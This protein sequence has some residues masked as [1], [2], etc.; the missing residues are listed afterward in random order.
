MAG[1]EVSDAVTGSTVSLMDSKGKTSW[2]PKALEITALLEDGSGYKLILHDV[3]KDSYSSLSVTSSG[4]TGKKASSL[5]NA[6]LLSLETTLGNDL[7]GDGALGDA[8]SAVSYD[9]SDTDLALS[10]YALSSGGYQIGIAGFE[11]SDAVTGSTVSLMDSKGKT[12]WTPKALEIAALLEDGSGYKLILHDVAKDSYSSLSVTSSGKTGKKASS[13]SNAELLSL[14]TTLGNDL[15]GDGALGD[16]VSAV[17]YDGSDTDLALSV[18]A[19]SSGGY[20][21]G[22][23]GFEVSDAV[24]GSTVSLM[25]SKGKTSWTP[26]ALEI[27]ALLEDGSGYKLILHDVAKDSYSSLSV[28]SS[29]K[30]GKKASSL[31]NAELLSLETTLGNDLNGD[32]ALGDAVSAVS[33]DGSDTDLALSVYALSSG[34]YQIGMAGFEVS[35]AVTGSTVSLMDSKGKTSWTPKALEIT[36]LLEDGSGYK[37]ILH[38]VAKDSYSSLS[39]TSS[40]KTGKKASSLSNA[41]LLSLETTLGND[42]NGD[43]ALGDAVSAVSYDGSDT[44]L[45]LSVYALSSG[46][47]Q[48]GMAGF[49]VSDAVTGSTVSLMDSK[50]KTSWTP[51]AL[52]ITALLEDGSG[53]KLIL[54]DVAKDSYSSLSVTSSGKTGKKASSL[55]NAELLSL[56]TTLGNDLNG[57]GALG[58]AISTVFYDGSET[59]LGLS[60]YELASGGY[61]IGGAGSVPGMA[62][63]KSIAT[64]MDSRGRSSWDPKNFDI[65]A[66]LE[67]GSGYKLI[68]HDA[69]KDSYSSLSVTSSGKTGKKASS[70]SHA[71]L[72]SL[73]TTIG[74]DLNGDG[75]LG[76]D[77]GR[78]FSLTDPILVNS[79]TTGS[80]RD[81]QISVLENG[82]IAVAW[83]SQELGGSANDVYLKIYSD[84]AGTTLEN[85]QIIHEYTIDSQYNPHLAGT[86]DGGLVVVFQSDG[87]KNVSFPE[88]GKVTIAAQAYDY[89]YDEMNS[90]FTRVDGITELPVN[91]YNAS[92]QAYPFVVEN[93]DGF[94][95]F[96][97]SDGQDGSGYGVYGKL[98]N[99]N[100]EDLLNID[101]ISI[102]N[103]T[104]GHQDFISGVSLGNDKT[105]LVFQTADNRVAVSILNETTGSLEN[106]YLVSADNS[107]PQWYPGVAALSDGGYVITWAESD[108]TIDVYCQFFSSEHQEMTEQIL[109]NSHTAGRQHLPTIA[110][111]E[112]DEIFIAWTSYDGQDGSGAGVYGQLFNSMGTKLGDEICLT[113]ETSGSQTDIQVDFLDADTVVY[114]YSQNDDVYFGGVDVM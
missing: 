63:R 106:E 13:L 37:L 98:Y 58:D 41:E 113:D 75:V 102:S 17:S 71:E 64:I 50:G 18:Y 33:Y 72:L 87:L 16:A 56:E 6:E 26:K 103:N 112:N 88:G 85:D 94:G 89:N 43:G 90:D 96:W 67:D 62:V 30:T 28:T 59:D 7:N 95:I 107:S 36:A 8:V 73:E 82:D 84:T 52:E 91:S 99:E 14:E 69:A 78:N 10:V 32:G 44:D 42:L 114:V 110:S 20:Q 3:A 61:E 101:D 70:L 83:Q 45:A 25:D 46:G 109:V 40:G 24:T 53:Y 47:Y 105:A 55:S 4:K 54:H 68:L 12:S 100:G 81:P 92:T 97:Q 80:Q 65:A 23:A 31:S 2:T 5:S 111:N 60:I 51:K 29:G 57:D 93:D 76:D 48:I 27:T 34:G 21:I 74:V 66:L 11:V 79:I 38:D 39:V 104:E 15:N 9:G 49:E 77:F 19:L 1:F 22:I 86:S 35:D 108:R